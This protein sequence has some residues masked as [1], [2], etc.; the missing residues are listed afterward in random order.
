MEY[1]Y[2]YRNTDSNTHTLNE[3]QTSKQSHSHSLSSFDSSSTA[4]AVVNEIK[5]NS[6]SRKVSCCH[7]Q[8]KQDVCSRAVRTERRRIF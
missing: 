1:L 2:G 4:I 8:R 3:F 7:Y 5:A 6:G